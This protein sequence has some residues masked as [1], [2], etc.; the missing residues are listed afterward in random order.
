MPQ[1]KPQTISSRCHNLQSW[2]QRCCLF[3]DVFLCKCFA[4]NLQLVQFILRI[5]LELP[6]L[7]VQECFSQRFMP[8]LQG[9]S[10]RFDILAADASGKQ[11]NIEIQRADSGAHVRRARYNSSI[12]DAAM[13]LPGEAYHKLHDSYVIFLTEKDPLHQELPICHIERVITETGQPFQDGSHII[14]ASARFQDDTPLGWLMH[15]LT[16]PD[17][18]QMYY[19]LL[20]D[21]VRHF[22]QT[23]EGVNAMSG[24]FEEFALEVASETNKETALRMLE[25]NSLPLEKIAL[26]TNLT[27][28]EVQALA[29]QKESA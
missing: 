12:L 21:N 24:V 28:A 27:V 22:K 16:C 15:D 9:R 19:P 8:N 25:D 4:H 6:D 29:V 13:P 10:V 1:T 5:V 18:A 23:Q 26:Y 20:A 17:P 3:D 14:Y 2:L 11:Y 7:Q